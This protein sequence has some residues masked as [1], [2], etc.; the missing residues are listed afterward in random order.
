MS[1]IPSDIDIFDIE[2]EGSFQ[3]KYGYK[4][5]SVRLT[6]KDKKSIYKLVAAG[7]NDEDAVREVVESVYHGKMHSWRFHGYGMER[8]PKHEPITIQPSEKRTEKCP[9]CQTDVDGNAKFC[10]SCGF[11]FSLVGSMK[12]PY[13]R[14]DISKSSKFCPECGKSLVTKCPKCGTEIPSGS[15]F[16][17][18]C[19][20]KVN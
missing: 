7:R 15:K 12:C 6:K 18:N 1:K 11:D 16:C 14:K 2:V 19:G 4:M 3:D 10:P 20:E 17:P 9:K 8:F 5:D 13:C